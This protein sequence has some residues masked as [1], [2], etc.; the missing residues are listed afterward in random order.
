MS[1][2]NDI[3]RSAKERQVEERREASDS[4]QIELARRACKAAERVADAAS[5]QA[6]AAERANARATIA[7]AIAI[8]SMM[9]TGFSI[10]ITLDTF[11]HHAF[12]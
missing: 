4:A 7:L 9:I 12:S 5:R 8:I 11:A 2:I 10:W 3:D 1:E 6:T